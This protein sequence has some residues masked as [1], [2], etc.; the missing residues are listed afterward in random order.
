MLQALNQ[1]LIWIIHRA[2]HTEVSQLFLQDKNPITK[3]TPK[4]RQIEAYSQTLKNHIML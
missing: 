2:K 3:K 4:A 1:I